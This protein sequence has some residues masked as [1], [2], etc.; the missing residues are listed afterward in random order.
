ML[1]MHV[2]AP[3]V[4]IYAMIWKLFELYLLRLFLSE[5]LYGLTKPTKQVKKKK[6]LLEI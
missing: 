5:L 2:F 4:E 3:L 6:I 1:M